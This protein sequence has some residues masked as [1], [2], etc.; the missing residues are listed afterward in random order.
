MCLSDLDKLEEIGL[1]RIKLLTSIQ[2]ET[3]LLESIL[4]NSL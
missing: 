2:N 1:E 3:K 4:N